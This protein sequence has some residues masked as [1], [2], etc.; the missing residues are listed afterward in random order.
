MQLKGLIDYFQSE[1]GGLHAAP[2]EPA[3]KTDGG[4]IFHIEAIGLAIRGLEDRW[5]KTDPGF[6]HQEENSRTEITSRGIYDKLLPELAKLRLIN[7]KAILL[8]VGVSALVIISLTAIFALKRDAK[9]QPALPTGPIP[10]D[11]SQN[12]QEPAGNET[13]TVGRET[14]PSLRIKELNSNLNIRSGPGTSY[15]VI[16]TAQPGSEYE[17]AGENQDWYEIRSANGSTGWVAKQF[18]EKITE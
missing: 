18:S 2:A 10:V 6:K 13:E 16:G 7:K 15:S 8:I 1:F 3:I 9:P 5:G 14:M 17:I 4:D 12:A 11:T